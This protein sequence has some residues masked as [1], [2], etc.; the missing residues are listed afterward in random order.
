LGVS[1]RDY[2]HNDYHVPFFYRQTTWRHVNERLL[3]SDECIWLVGVVETK[4][5][6]KSSSNHYHDE[7]RKRAWPC[8]SAY[9][10]A[11]YLHGLS[12]D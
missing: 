5:R 1:D 7:Q 10:N 3:L 4:R 2:R 6:R 11:G 12:C 8:P 9:Y